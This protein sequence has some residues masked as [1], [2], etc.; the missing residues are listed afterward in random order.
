LFK[1]INISK[2]GNL[3]YVHVYSSIYIYVYVYVYMYRE[4]EKIGERKKEGWI[5]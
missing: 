1:E 4:R 2:D 3:V 5:L